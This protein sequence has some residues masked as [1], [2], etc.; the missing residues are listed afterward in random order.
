MLGRW[1]RTR[2][3]IDACGMAAVWA[4]EMMLI[5]MCFVMWVVERKVVG[6]AAHYSSWHLEL[7]AWIFDIIQYL[8]STVQPHS[9]CRRLFQ[10]MTSQHWLGQLFVMKTPAASAA[11]AKEQRA[12]GRKRKQKERMRRRAAWAVGD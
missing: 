7:R 5:V 9:K 6:V 2:I 8:S 10:P 12:R 11:T 1:R 3:E 4:W